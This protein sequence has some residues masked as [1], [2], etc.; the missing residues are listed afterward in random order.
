MKTGRGVMLGFVMH[1]FGCIVCLLNIKLIE[2]VSMANLVTYKTLRLS[3][4]RALHEHSA[5]KSKG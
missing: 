3:Q 5:S 4:A 2:G 1:F